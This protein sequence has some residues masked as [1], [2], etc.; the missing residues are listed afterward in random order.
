M[1]QR[2]PSV[3]LSASNEF[4][5]LARYMHHIELNRQQLQSAFNM[6]EDQYSPTDEPTHTD[7]FVTT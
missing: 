3:F 4:D 7:D 2:T 6:I 5:N 1:A